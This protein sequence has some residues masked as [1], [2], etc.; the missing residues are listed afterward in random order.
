MSGAALLLSD[1]DSEVDSFVQ[2]D[3]PTAFEETLKMARDDQKIRK[4]VP[5]K[6]PID[7]NSDPFGEGSI[8]LEYMSF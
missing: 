4:N 2:P 1:S 8:Y 5:K 6:R 7:G 3:L